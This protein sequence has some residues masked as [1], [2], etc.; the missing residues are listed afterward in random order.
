M[1]K[2]EEETMKRIILFALVAGLIATQASADMFEMDTKTALNL[3]AVSFSDDSSSVPLGLMSNNL[4]YI[5]INPGDATDNELGYPISYNSTNDMLFSVG[6]SGT[7]TDLNNDGVASVDI[8]AAANTNG[9]LDTLRGLG[10]NIDEYR[11]YVANDNAENWAYNLY[12]V[13]DDGSGG[14]DRFE[15]S[16]LTTLP[17][18]GI[19]LLTL[20]FGSNQDFSQLQDLG[21]TISTAGTNDKFHTSVVPVPAAA[22]LGVLGLG[23]AGLKLRKYA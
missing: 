5:G 9:V 6:F 4:T 7:L 16:P 10:S 12:A 8:G 1:F 18:P 3:R 22:L 11:L 2:K 20:N 19:A 21:F 23:I 15:S 14:T 17:A 13:F